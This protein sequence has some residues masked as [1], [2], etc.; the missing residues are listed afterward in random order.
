MNVAELIDILRDLDPETTVEMAIVAPVPDDSEEITV[1]QYPIEGVLPRDPS[2][3]EGQPMVWLIGGEATDVD[4][5]IDAIE[6]QAD[7]VL[8]GQHGDLI[9]FKTASGRRHRPPS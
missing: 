7:H 9:D 1:D 2:D 4:E 8:T 3:H 5:F 6:T